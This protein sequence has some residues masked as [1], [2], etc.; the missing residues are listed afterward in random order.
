MQYADRL[1]QWR[2]YKSAQGPL[3]PAVFEKDRINA[4]NIAHL[5]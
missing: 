3:V 1:H 4:T 5:R 2:E